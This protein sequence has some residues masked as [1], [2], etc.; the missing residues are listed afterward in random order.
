MSHV[1]LLNI[2]I[3][4]LFSF[5]FEYP[6]KNFGVDICSVNLPFSK[7]VTK[8][9]IS[10]YILLASGDKYRC[11]WGAGGIFLAWEG[12]NSSLKVNNMMNFQMTHSKALT[13]II[14]FV[15]VDYYLIICKLSVLKITESSE[16]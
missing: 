7:S 6:M 13:L 10:I 14:K 4:T 16:I 5:K 9:H 15:K 12:C 1:D 11:S 3:F 2:L 8:F